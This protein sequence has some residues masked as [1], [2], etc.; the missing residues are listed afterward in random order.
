MTA[1]GTAKIRPGARRD[2]A[3][4][5]E[6]ANGLARDLE[7][8][9]GMMDAEA[10]TTM[11]LGD[12][13]PCELFVAELDGVVA[14]YALHQAGFETAFAV[15]GRFLNDLYVDPAF[16]RRGIGRALLRAVARHAADC[17]EVYVNWLTTLGDEGARHLYASVAD[18]SE[19]VTAMAVTRE[20]FRRLAEEQDVNQ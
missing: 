15:P 17:G 12:N 9:D 6:L 13:S 4:I 14:G 18:V 19:Q 8:S 1:A 2:A 3:R 5:A 16:R 7:T 20:A 11:L 10:V